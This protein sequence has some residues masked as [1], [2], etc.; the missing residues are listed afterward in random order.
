MHTTHALM[1][2]QCLHLDTYTLTHASSCSA[3]AICSWKS[4]KRRNEGWCDAYT[5]HMTTHITTHMTTHITTHMP[6]VSQAT[7]DTCAHATLNTSAHA[8][9]EA[10]TL[11]TDEQRRKTKKEQRPTKRSFALRA[12]LHTKHYIVTHQQRE[13]LSC[14]SLRSVA[15]YLNIS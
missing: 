5:T 1:R 13:I 12:F 3:H 10:S 2:C 14:L 9:R 8:S 15:Y 6:T 4:N 7:L 11:F